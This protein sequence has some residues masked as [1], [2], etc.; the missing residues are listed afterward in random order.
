MSAPFFSAFSNSSAAYR[1]PN[2]PPRMRMRCL[3]MI[4]PWKLELRDF[5]VH[6]DGAF[7]VGAFVE[8]F[9]V[10]FKPI[11]RV[12]EQPLQPA[13]IFRFGL[14]HVTHSHLEVFAVRIH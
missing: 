11:N 6:L 14:R 4:P 3:D 5:A 9:R 12:S 7:D 1:P 13:G 10:V 2:P 8:K